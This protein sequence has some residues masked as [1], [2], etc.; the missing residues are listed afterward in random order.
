MFSEGFRQVPRKLI[1]LTIENPTALWVYCYLVDKMDDR[2][3]MTCT[4]NVTL[5]AKIVG[6]PKTTLIR[7]MQFLVQLEAISIVA[8][9]KGY[10]VKA[11]NYQNNPVV[12][13]WSE[14]G[15]KTVRN[16]V[17]NVV[18]KIELEDSG[19]K[20]IFGEHTDIVGPTFGPTFG[21]TYDQNVVR[22]G[23]V[24]D[25]IKK[26]RK[27]K[28]Y[29]LSTASVDSADSQ[30]ETKTP[31]L[32][33]VNHWNDNL[34]THQKVLVSMLRKNEK[35]KKAITAIIDT[36]GMNTLFDVIKG[37]SESDFLN[38]KWKPKFEWITK[39]DNVQKVIEGNY[40]DTKETT[41]KVELTDFSRSSL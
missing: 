21:P 10:T 33:L 26:E 14:N 20:D 1:R 11:L 2:L 29:S 36:V 31:W 15:P 38:K 41:K 12:K 27:K 22:N 18:R 7:L 13:A 30:D 19:I 6:I 32:T 9:R 16:L 8:G 24:L 25:S 17:R 34:P 23:G 28:E 39:I 3:E 35:R 4:I 5:T 37:I 40:K